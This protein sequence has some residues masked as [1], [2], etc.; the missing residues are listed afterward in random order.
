MRRTALKHLALLG[1]T[2]SA[3]TPS[4]RA[5]P[6]EPRLLG[7]WVSDREKTLAL[8]RFHP[9]ASPETRDKVAALFG[10]LRL[11]FTA[12]DVRAM[13]DGIE[14]VHAYRV[15]ASDARSVVLE[16]TLDGGRVLEQVFFEGNYCYKL[17]GYNL[18]YFRRTAA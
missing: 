6:L 15:L 7:A 10:R 12:T 13:Q 9:E 2:A 17:A 4:T 18:E 16:T 3:A 11:T 14:T 1:L 5:M 8:W